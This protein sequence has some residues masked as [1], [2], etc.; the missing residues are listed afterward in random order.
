MVDDVE[1]AK[2]ELIPGG[3]TFSIPLSLLLLTT[4]LLVASFIVIPVVLLAYAG[5]NESVDVVVTTM[6]AAYA[7]QV[8]G[9]VLDGCNTIYKVMYIV[10]SNE[11]VRNTVDTI[12]LANPPI[13]FNNQRLMVA[14]YEAIEPFQYIRY[15]GYTMPDRRNTILV[16]I[17]GQF[18][19]DCHGGNFCDFIF[20]TNVSAVNGTF[21]VM[22]VPNG[23]N[24]TNPV[25]MRNEVQGY[26]DDP[27]F[28]PFG[29][30]QILTV[31]GLNWA[32]WRGVPLGEDPAKYNNPDFVGYLN[33]G[34]DLGRYTD[35]LK[36]VPVT[37]N[38][39]IAIWQS[40]GKMIG[41]NQDGLVLNKKAAV[42]AYY[43]ADEHPL[44]VIRIPAAAVLQKYGRWGA[45]PDKV[46]DEFA[47]SIGKVW[48]ELRAIR[49]EHELEWFVMIAIPES[50]VMG[51]IVASR[52]KVI[53]TSIG[54]A[55]AMLAFAA[56]TSFLV[57]RPL[58]M[59]TEVMTRATGM[60][61]SDLSSGYLLRKSRISEINA[62]Q[63][64]FG[65]M[66]TKFSTA[67][68]ANRALI[69]GTT[70]SSDSKPDTDAS[71]SGGAV[72]KSRRESKTRFKGSSAPR[73]P[74]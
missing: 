27:L 18:G 71:G 38:T 72:E 52:K 59:L 23:L 56:A 1:S 3:K 22:R 14:F 58:R 33:T 5:A 32:I 55:F 24:N 66:M 51:P 57:S 74:F 65:T 17:E 21:D 48:M 68:K 36:E 6:R 50:D 70:R 42:L 67:I 46:S 54:V 15:I 34:Q 4:S 45:V 31:V 13:L 10:A 60:D 20:T 40:K 41:G 64:V 25:A 43:L 73:P 28:F 16:P 62:M 8:T 12:D 19:V 61:F 26:W 35:L 47:T 49:D 7:T 9:K 44:D 11:R 37:K 30:N 39:V 69:T 29:E 53:G 63:T 2:K